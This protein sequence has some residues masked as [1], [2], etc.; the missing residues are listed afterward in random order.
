[1]T[2]ANSLSGWWIGGGSGLAGTVVGFLIPALVTRRKD[3]GDLGRELLAD[4]IARLEKVEADAAQCH[5]SNNMLTLRCERNE[6]VSDLMLNE[7][8]V[9]APDSPVIAQ[10]RRILKR[11]FST[12]M[13]GPIDSPRDMAAT[14]DQIP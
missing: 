4:T 2:D 11:S 1:M 9:R 3:A 6:F 13:D 10:A 14:L 7:L 12:A 5:R 8:E